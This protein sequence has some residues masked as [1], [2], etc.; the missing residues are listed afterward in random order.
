MPFEQAGTLIQMLDD[1]GALERE[2]GQLKGRLTQLNRRINEAA[3]P[4]LE[5]AYLREGKPSGI[6]RFPVG[7]HF[8][9]A[10]VDKRVTWDSDILHGVAVELPPEQAGE[11]FKVTY[12]MAETAFKAITDPKLKAKLTTARTV[13]YGEPKISVAD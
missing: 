5:S 4:A 9:K 3:K 8:F 12:T 2:I 7:N 11:L 1:R 13:K 6:I 10:E